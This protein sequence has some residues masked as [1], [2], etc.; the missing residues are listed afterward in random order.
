MNNSNIS[1]HCIQCGMP[2][3]STS[4]FNFTSFETSN[5]YDSLNSPSSFRVIGSPGVPK[6]TSSPIPPK[7]PKY[8]NSNTQ[9]AKDKIPLKILNMNFQSIKN[10]KAELLEIIDTVKPDIILGTETWLDPNISS[11]EYFPSELY[12]VYRHDR[13]PSTNNVSYGGVLVAISKDFISSEVKT[14][15]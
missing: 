12:N 7:L 3:F 6:A 5:T 10:K 8:K 14:R 4:F 9:R 15:N 1:W 13:I 11:Y 2:N